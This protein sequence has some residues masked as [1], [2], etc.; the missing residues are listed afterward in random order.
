MTIQAPDAQVRVGPGF[1]RRAMDYVG[2]YVWPRSSNRPR[3]VQWLLLHPLVFA[4]WFHSRRLMWRM[5]GYGLRRLQIGGF[6]GDKAL[7]YNLSNQWIINRA[8]TERL[9]SIVEAIQGLDRGRAR[10]LVVG[11]R[12][13]AELLLLRTHG[14]A[15][16]NIEAIDLFT[17]CPTIKL[18]DMHDLGYPDNSFDAVYSSFVITYSDDIPKA[19]AETVRVAKDR[20]VIIFGFQH[21]A[22]D[23]TNKLGVNRLQGGTQ[24]L[25]GLFGNSV[26]HVYWT[27]DLDQPDCSRICTVVFRLRKS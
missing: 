11:P 27:D 7:P 21:L 6:V 20:A 18:M 22:P 23:A 19:L 15:G 1:R 10:I 25:L 13:E 3:L 9:M 14:F 8:R 17:Y 12:N 26:G 24:E 4:A 2:R 5:R 16:R